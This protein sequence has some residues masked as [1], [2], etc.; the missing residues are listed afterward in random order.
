MKIIS[1]GK[2]DTGL[3]RTKNED[4]FCSEE[5]IGLFIVADGIGGHAAGEIASAMA[6]EVIKDYM[7]KSLTGK[8]QFIKDV[9]T[10]FLEVTNR[11]SSGIELANQKIYKTS[12]DSPKFSSMG[13]TIAVALLTGCRLSIAHVGDSRIYLVRDNS[14]LRLTDDHSVISEHI[15]QGLMTK[16]EA[17]RANFGNIITRAVGYEE[18]VDIEL[19]EIN[20]L[21]GDKI[22]LCSD[23][24]TSMVKDEFILSTVTSVD[25]PEEACTVLIEKACENGG[26]DNITVII[27]F[28]LQNGWLS[29]LKEYFR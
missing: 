16:E 14:L 7:R 24:L 27:I 11:I 15:K 9:N 8:E 12:Q 2:T 20:V 25:S 5:D 29:K 18:T 6:V 28:I 17:E 26:K 22:I 21:E 4:S 23:G 3:V 1:F 19:D 10:R 13:T